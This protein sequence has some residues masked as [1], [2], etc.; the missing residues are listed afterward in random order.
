[1]KEKID[2]SQPLKNVR[3]ERFVYGVFMGL[4][5]ATA[6]KSAGYKSKDECADI[7]ASRLLSSVKV[8]ARLAHLQTKA[9]SAKIMTKQRAMEI[10]S[11]MIECDLS[12]FMT[13]GADGVTHFDFGKDTVKRK[14]L[15]K[16][17]TKTVRDEAGNEV[18]ETMFQEM[19]LESKTTAMERLAKM[20]GW[21]Q[22]LRQELTGADGKPLNEPVKIIVEHV[23]IN[24]DHKD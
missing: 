20:M 6:Y 23:T 15:K 9:A 24:A 4:P 17:K 12:D 5:H 7:A 16:V 8:S 2:P 21:D 11:E 13:V 22:P 3:Q 14:A 1:V 18:M 19:E 10:L